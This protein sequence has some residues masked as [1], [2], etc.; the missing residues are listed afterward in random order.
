MRYVYHDEATLPSAVIAE[1]GARH[2][3]APVVDG[4]GG[5]SLFRKRRMQLARSRSFRLSVC[6][7]QITSLSKAAN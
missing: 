5:V 7:T 4:A 6:K 2:N 3:T 1:D